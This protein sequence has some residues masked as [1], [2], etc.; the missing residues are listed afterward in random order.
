MRESLK[1]SFAKLD[2]EK[3]K[4]SKGLFSFQHGAAQD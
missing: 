3:Q 1:C 2:I 4:L